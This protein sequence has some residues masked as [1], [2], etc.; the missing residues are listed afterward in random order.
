MLMKLKLFPYSLIPVLVAVAGVWLAATSHAQSG[1]HFDLSWSTLGG[2]G[3]VS[4]NGRFTMSGTVGQPDAGS[5]S[6]GAFK[7]EGG[8]WSG[9][10]VDETTAGP[11]LKIRLT[12][13]GQAILSWPL[14]AQDYTLEEA[15]GAVPPIRWTRATQTVVDTSTE[16]TVT[17]P[18]A[19]VIQCYRLKK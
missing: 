7:I 12:R 16:H 13:G 9:I 19:G 5:L 4:S 15:A 11:V 10:T 8:F 1:G 17:V 18:A 2:G 14:S 6:G 3:G